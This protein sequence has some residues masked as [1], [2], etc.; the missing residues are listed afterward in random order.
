M[1]FIRNTDPFTGRTI[2]GKARNLFFL[3][4]LGLHVPKWIVIPQEALEELVPGAVRMK[5]APEICSFIDSITIAPGVINGITAHFPGVRFFA[6]RSSAIDEDGEEF[7]FAGQF[8]S[9]LFITEDTLA[10][11]IKKVW[12][13]AFS[14]RVHQYRKNNAL[15][16]RFGIAVIIQEMIPAESAGVAFGADPITGDRKAKLISSVYGLGEGLVS[17][18]LDADNFLLKNGSITATLALKTHKIIFNAAKQYGT[19]KIGVEPSKQKAPSLGEQQVKEIGRVLDVCAKAYGKPQDMEFA[20]VNGT[21][22]LLQSRPITSLGQMP[23]KEGEYIVWDNSNIIESYPGVTT[24]LTFSFIIKMYEAVYRQLSGLMGVSPKEIDEHADVFANMLGLLKGRVYYNLLS[25]Y[26]ALSLLPGYSINAGFMEKMMGVKERFELKEVKQRTRFRERLRVLN[27]VRVMLKNN[28]QLPGMRERFQADFNAVMKRYD[29]IDLGACRPEE[30]MVLY[31]RF[32]QTL[33]RKWKAPLVNDF[34]AMIYFGVMQK[35]VVKYGISGNP[36]IGNDLLC[37]AKDIISTEPVKRSLAI[38][39]AIAGDAEAKKMF[40][41]KS[42]QEILAAFREGKFPG[43]KKQ[44]DEYIL[45]FGERCVGELKL[46]TVTYRQNPAAFIRII[47]SYVQQGVTESSRNGSIEEELRKNAEAQVRKALSAKPVKRMIF[48]YFLRKARILVS[49]R[50]NLRYERTRGFGMVRQIFC[51]IGDRFYAEGMIG[52]P[53]DIFYLTKEEIFDHIRGTS[54]NGDIRRLIAL[55]KEEYRGFEKEEP[56]ERIVTYGTVYHGN[57]FRQQKKEAALQGDLKGTGCCP[58][59][60]KAKVRVVKDPNEVENLNG[61]ILVTSSTDPG[62][63]TLFPTASAILVER[64]SLLSHSAI[65]SR[66]M[67]KPCIVGITGLLERLASG[68]EVEMD[69]STG[70]VKIISKTNAA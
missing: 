45:K 18:E 48:G 32:E 22:Y 34:F 47:R 70:E 17:G 68:D 40:L 60:V 6:V 27:M 52:H 58:G 4:A 50:E 20:A 63:V 24:P 35:L 29:A 25:W 14:D 51:A 39:T 38:A 55:R 31:G 26:K 37:G 54:V 19:E 44:V 36:G 2:G 12:K 64:G 61:D 56:A 67:G 65:V 9:F 33:L 42:E 16:M 7:S 10:E 43:I 23:D 41:E 30:L 15:G 8:E 13:S 28:R 11:H 46:E 49:Q 69:G 62:W 5:S 53:R 21:I 3:Q 57:S 59:R 1:Q 66:E